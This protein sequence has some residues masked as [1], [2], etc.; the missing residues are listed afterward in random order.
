MASTATQ[1]EE[2][3]EWGRNIKD[4]EEENEAKASLK[5]HIL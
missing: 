5:P 4:V 1:R 2:H 3:N